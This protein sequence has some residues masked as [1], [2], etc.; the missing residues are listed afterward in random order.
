[1]GAT[2]SPDRTKVKHVFPWEEKPR[3]MP[4]RVFPTADAP[5]PSLFLSPGSQVPASPSLAEHQPIRAQQAL[6]PLQGLPPTLTYANA[7]DTVPSI[8]K[9]ASRLVRPPPPPPPLAPAFDDG[10]RRRGSESYR[11]WDERTE[12]SSRDGDVEDEGDDEDEADEPQQAET[13][14][15]DD[16]HKEVSSTLPKARSRSGSSVSASYIIKGKKKDYRVRGVQTIPREMRSQGVQVTI[17]PPKVPHAQDQDKPSF[18]PGTLSGRREWGPTTGS[19]VLPPVTVH[20]VSAGA[21]LSMTTALPSPATNPPQASVARPSPSPPSLRSPREFE[22]PTPP[23]AAKPAQQVSTPPSKP[24]L[25]TLQRK[26]SNDGSSVASPLSSV[27][28]LSPVDVPIISPARKAGRVW[29]PARGVEL[30]KRGSEE[31]LARFLKMGAWD[32]DGAR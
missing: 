26:F 11:S 27:G 4:G 6:S 31:V 22:F 23:P 32:E 19:R 30:F 10:R 16:S 18:H 17:D 28:P 7:W 1:M 14:W 12:A 5:S 2:P 15:D 8:Q 3:H 25:Q 29:D 13:T 20:E 24:I 9:Y 21:D